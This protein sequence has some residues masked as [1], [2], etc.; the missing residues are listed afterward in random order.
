MKEVSQRLVKFSETALLITSLK[1]DSYKTEL[2]P[3]SVNRLVNES[4]SE[5][6]KKYP[7]TNFKITKELCQDKVLVNV[8]SELM[9]TCFSQ[10]IDNAYKYAGKN[11]ELRISSSIEGD[12]LCV[13]FIDN[14]P[15]FSKSALENLF[16]VFAAGDILHNEGSGLGLAA[17]KLALDANEASIEAKN[18]ESGGAKISIKMTYSANP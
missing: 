16:D 12:K 13:N 18:I 4:I 17:T 6:Q 3:V 8:D 7:E 15:G 5:F 10:L 9:K 11:A 14:G 1:I 2:M